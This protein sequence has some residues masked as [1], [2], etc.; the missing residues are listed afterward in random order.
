MQLGFSRFLKQ[1]GCL[2]RVFRQHE[3]QDVFMVSSSMQTL[4]SPRSMIL[5]YLVERLCNDLLIISR[6]LVILFFG[7]LYE[8]LKGHFFVQINV[9]K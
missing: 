1:F 4:K 7:G 3:L 2:M 9:N 8:E 6:C 5:S